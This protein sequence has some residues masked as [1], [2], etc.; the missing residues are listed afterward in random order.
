MSFSAVWHTMAGCAHP[1]SMEFCA[2]VDYV[3]IGWLIS[4]SVGTVVHYGF[5]C[6]PTLGNYFLG[7]CFLTGLAGNICP[8][9][10]WFN[11]IEYRGWR[12]VFFLTLAFSSLAPLATLAMLHSVRETLDFMA[13]VVPSLV[14]Y[15][16][17]LVFYA[18]QVPERFLPERWSSKL[19]IV[20]GGSHCIWHCFIVLASASYEV[21]C[22]M[23]KTAATKIAHNSTIPS[24]AINKDLKPL[25][26][27]INV[28]KVVLVSI[29]KLS[30]DF[31][32]S[33]EAL[34]TWGT[35]EGED[36]GDTLTAACNLLN[37]FSTALSQYATHEHGIR[38]HMK[39][40][41]THEEALDELKRRRKALI[42][43]ADTAEKKL[44]KMSPEHKNLHTQT[45][46]LNSL[47]EEIR[48]MDSQIMT[49][50]AALGD[51]KRSKTRAF[52]GLKFG[53]LL[54]C[55]EKGAIAG[56]F[57]RLVANEIPDVVTQPGMPR[58]VYLNRPR[59]E[60]LLTDAYRCVN[61][62]TFST[63]PAPDSRPRE[64]A[65]P[66]AAFPPIEGGDSLNTSQSLGTGHFMYATDLSREMSTVSGNSDPTVPTSPVH[67]QYP[68]YQYYPEPSSPVPVPAASMPSR[69]STE[70]F[71][72]SAPQVNTGDG[73]GGGR[74][75]TFPVKSTH[76]QG[77]GLRDD[78]P[79][80][81]RGKTQDE[82]SFSHS[83][84]A[85]LSANGS[86]FDE[87][88]PAYDLPLPP[89]A[90]APSAMHDPWAGTPSQIH[91]HRHES[92]DDDVGLAYMSNQDEDQV[93]PAAGHTRQASEK[94]V[95][96]GEVQDVDAELTNRHR[97][98]ESLPTQSSPSKRIPP[99][100]L[101][102]EEE[103]RELNA[104]AAREISREMDAL[105]FRPPEFTPNREP[106]PLL[107]P[108]QPYA[109]PSQIDEP[110]SP[111]AD[112]GQRMSEPPHNIDTSA[113]SHG[114]ETD[115]QPRT[116]M[117][118]KDSEP[119]ALAMPQPTINIPERSF[120]SPSGNP[121]SPSF[122]TPP[123]YP[124]LGASP[125]G[126]R[127]VSSLSATGGASPGGTPVPPPAG[128]RTISAAAFRRGAPRTAS[129]SELVADG[130]SGLGAARGPA[131][132][133]PLH[134]KKRLPSSPYPP[135]DGSLGRMSNSDGR[136]R[137]GSLG[138]ANANMNPSPRL[139]QAGGED[140]YDYLSAYTDPPPGTG[141]PA[142]SDFGSLGQMRVMNDYGAPSPGSGGYSQGRFATDLEKDSLR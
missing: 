112:Y 36:L 116:S 119:P 110:P 130:S 35:G 39:A 29:Q 33:A 78:A 56:E 50:E 1:A 49:E 114:I 10:D 138:N 71:G 125:L 87:P 103:A 107:P 85:A 23:F 17:G 57:G 90:A 137:S 83:V 3:G 28:E 63:V 46:T 127:S 44:S 45:Q 30:V 102:P 19:D 139:S 118:P 22:K 54:E 40:I 121:S 92:D 133:S 109:Q 94:Q 4:A 25:Q 129:N 20:G 31:S 43:R 105:N 95:R 15:V 69:R 91:H 70:E 5:Q 51:M 131:D 59:V 24:L 115:R 88:A 67:A 120:S 74:F 79:T 26:D 136:D 106:S 48:M 86:S 14:S 111:R 126:Q 128:V 7:L 117:S 32:K 72:V 58:S 122:R 13:P 41:R 97:Q 52:L 141:S 96:F 80:L 12:I 140:D 135:R 2:R 124:R 132:T 64:R 82:D 93:P 27:L 60:G 16:I 98:Q 66:E 104:A 73:P 89:G 142:R 9:M 11:K 8:F 113:T 61:E 84:A 21:S 65:A 134:L 99:P 76:G 101:S 38:E 37:H 62:V 81:D 34:R 18:S 42:S 123:E 47:Q 6:Y 53:G 75:A 68:S 108:V 100:S 77:Y 55:C